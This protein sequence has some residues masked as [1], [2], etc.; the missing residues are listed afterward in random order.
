[1][2]NRTED[3][4]SSNVN[5]LLQMLQQSKDSLKVLFVRLT[6]NETFGSIY[7]EK[8]VDFVDSFIL[9]PCQ[10]FRV[11]KKVEIEIPSIISFNL[12]TKS[13][14]VSISSN[15]LVRASSWPG[16]AVLALLRRSRSVLGE[17]ATYR[18]FSL[19]D[20]AV[21]IHPGDQ[22][23]IFKELLDSR[24]SLQELNLASL[25]SLSPGTWEFARNCKQLKSIALELDGTS[26]QEGILTE[27]DEGLAEAVEL[28]VP[29]GMEGR[30]SV[31]H[32]SM[33]LKGYTF[34]KGSI[35]QWLDSALETF[36]LVDSNL[37]SNLPQAV[38]SS[39]IRS[40][41]ISS[42][43]S[44]RHLGLGG[45]IEVNDLRR[46][47]KLAKALPNLH[48]LKLSTV[49]PWFHEFFQDVETPLLQELSIS[50]GQER[51]L[52]DVQ[53]AFECL[54]SLVKRYSSNLVN[55][56]FTHGDQPAPDLPSSPP[57][58]FKEL[59][60]ISINYRVYSESELVGSWFS[61]FI[62]PKLTVVRAPGKV[63]ERF[64]ESGNSP[65]LDP[66]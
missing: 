20:A 57:L 21:A 63:L 61:R 7:F 15:Q 35:G 22:A 60:S 11:L 55:L 39:D 25:Y 4:D 43:S 64:I 44:L 18:N 48:S 49:H 6:W 30:A 12:G 33:N 28:L 3:W 54:H 47:T 38:S 1:M 40:I 52:N 62:Y 46:S 42:H 9:D 41:L 53:C 13:K 27:A 31:E 2:Y 58:Y 24:E 17:E 16:E 26:L 37:W 34:R 19:P 59:E 10:E 8:I 50:C 14:M 51:R 65:N 5:Q 23:Q 66:Y 36:K 32:L 45:I 56:V 29:E